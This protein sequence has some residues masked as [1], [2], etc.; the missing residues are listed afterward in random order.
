[1]LFESFLQN[2]IKN[3]QEQ[4]DNAKLMNTMKLTRTFTCWKGVI[5]FKRSKTSES[6]KGKPQSKVSQSQSSSLNPHLEE[7]Y[8]GLIEEF[9]KVNFNS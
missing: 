8:F 6:S 4:E 7:E 9:R 2:Y 3:F 5:D 1:M